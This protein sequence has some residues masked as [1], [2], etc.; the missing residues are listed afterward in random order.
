MKKFLI[1][2]LAIVLAVGSGYTTLKPPTNAV[3]KKWFRFD[4]DPG[5]EMDA[6]LY[7]VV[8]SPSCPSTTASYRCEIFIETQ[9]SDAN[10]PDLSNTPTE[11][12]KKTNP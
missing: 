11:E 6:S 2:M 12:R 5:E 10:Q 7:T 9:V 4:G 3:E 8:S 1:P